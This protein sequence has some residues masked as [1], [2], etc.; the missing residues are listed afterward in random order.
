M[1]NG[2]EIFKFLVVGDLIFVLGKQ[3]GISECLVI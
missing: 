1:E 2:F 3:D